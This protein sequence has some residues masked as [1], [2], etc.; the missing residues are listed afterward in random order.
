MT[1]SLG[2]MSML[3]RKRDQYSLLG[4]Q[5]FLSFSS[6]YF[7]TGTLTPSHHTTSASA[8]D[9]TSALLP[10]LLHIVGFLGSWASGKL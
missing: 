2:V 5:A 3:E 8:N 9:T 10:E 1:K 7:V 4:L 6:M